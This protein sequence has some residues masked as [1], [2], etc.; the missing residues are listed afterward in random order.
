M[1]LYAVIK[2]GE[3]INKIMWDGKSEYNPGE[4]CELLLTDLPIDIKDKY[5]DG[6]FERYNEKEDIWKEV[7]IEQKK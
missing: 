1:G 7:T 3:V 2:D 5:E 6:K 4:G